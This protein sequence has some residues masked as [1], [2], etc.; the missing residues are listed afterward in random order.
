[1]ILPR[2]FYI[3]AFA[4]KKGS[5]FVIFDIYFLPKMLYNVV[6]QRN[7]VAASNAQRSLFS[8]EYQAYDTNARGI[9]T[10]VALLFGV[11]IRVIGSV[12]K[13]CLFITTD[14]ICVFG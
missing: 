2:I 1:M 6:T 9:V 13:H 12:K 10:V 4:R 14:F 7:S 11:L 5:I 3:V 8:A